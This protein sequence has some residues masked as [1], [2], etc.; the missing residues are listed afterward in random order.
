MG[1][2]PVPFSVSCYVAGSYR[3]GPRLFGLYLALRIP[4][5]LLFYLLVRLGW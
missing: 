4:R 1:L 2:V 5:L 3:I